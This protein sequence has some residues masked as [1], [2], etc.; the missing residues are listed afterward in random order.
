MG[1]S[2]M[3]MYELCQLKI[4]NIPM[5]LLPCKHFTERLYWAHVRNK[6]VIQYVLVQWQTK[7]RYLII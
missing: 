2:G 3:I 7:E 6:N 4:L 5:N 1:L